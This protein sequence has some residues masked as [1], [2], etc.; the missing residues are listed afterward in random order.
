MQSPDYPP[1]TFAFHDKATIPSG[2]VRKILVRDVGRRRGPEATLNQRIEWKLSASSITTKATAGGP[3]PPMSSAGLLRARPMLRFANWPKAA[4]PS[5]WAEQQN[6]STTFQLVS[7]WLPSRRLGRKGASLGR[8]RLHLSID[9]AG[10][11]LN[12]LAPP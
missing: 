2:L 5:P 6:W 4:S 3:S 1:L 7:A 11:G 10:V 12:R 9:G 8:L